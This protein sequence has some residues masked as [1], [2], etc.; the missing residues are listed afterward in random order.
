MKHIVPWLMAGLSLIATHMGAYQLG[1]WINQP[2]VSM[3]I[4]EAV[5]GERAPGLVR[6]LAAV[7]HSASGW[8]AEIPKAA[9]AQC[10]TDL[11]TL[12]KRANACAVQ[13]GKLA[14]AREQIERVANENAAQLAVDE[15]VRIQVRYEL[16]QGDAAC[17]DWGNRPLCPGLMQLREQ[18]QFDRSGAHPIR[19]D[20][21]GAVGTDNTA[22]SVSSAG[23]QQP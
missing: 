13:V 17:A 4:A 2:R 10:Q 15:T 8:F 1:A 5:A 18:E 14:E 12:S 3:A 20:P 9:F 16:Y 21:A 23:T 6:P 7:L 11:L 19:A 22:E